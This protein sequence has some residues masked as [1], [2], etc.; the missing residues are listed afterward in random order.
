[1]SEEKEEKEKKKEKKKDATF[2]R[3]SRLSNTIL[4]K[5]VTWGTR[6]S[7]LSDTL[8]YCRTINL[9]DID[10]KNFDLNYQLTIEMIK[11]FLIEKE[12]K[13][14]KNNVNSKVDK[15]GKEGKER[16]EGKEKEEE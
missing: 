9:K 7:R 10:L 16:Q 15:D 12:E 6:D 1:M 4:E 11:Q 5:R 2:G 14:L 13:K 8:L 3:D